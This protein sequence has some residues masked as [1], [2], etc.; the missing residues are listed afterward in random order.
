MAHA[1]CEHVRRDFPNHVCGPG[2][3]PVI[4]ALLCRDKFRKR[5]QQIGKGSA[6]ISEISER[7]TCTKSYVTAGIAEERS[8]RR[9][10]LSGLECERAQSTSSAGDNALILFS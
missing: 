7:R 4:G 3:D 2:A 6:M 5:G 10:D 9:D 8:E 1:I